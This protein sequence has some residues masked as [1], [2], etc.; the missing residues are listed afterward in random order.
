MRKDTLR[1]KVI[2]LFIATSACILDQVTKVLVFSSVVKEDY[3]PIFSAFGGFFLIEHAHN[4]GAVFGIGQGMNS[5]FALVSVLFLVI[6]IPFFFVH[7]LPTKGTI[8][9]A[10][11][12][13]L[14]YGGVAGN[15]VDRILFSAVRDFITVG[16][17]PTFNIADSCICIGVAYFAWRVLFDKDIP[18]GANNEP[19]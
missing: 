17:W 1:L 15:F 19:V 9:A 7:Y 4:T 3:E 18:Q 12:G 8:L 16:P 14:A 2:F 13:G 6:M 10:I 11:V 5:A